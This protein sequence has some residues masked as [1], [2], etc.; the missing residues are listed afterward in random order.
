MMK[1]PI[2]VMLMEAAMLAG[3]SLIFFVLR[4]L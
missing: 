3:L 4:P 1:I 2:V